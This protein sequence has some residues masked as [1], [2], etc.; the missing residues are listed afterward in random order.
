MDRRYFL[1]QTAFAIMAIGAAAAVGC[2]SKDS[3]SGAN[4]GIS[5]NQPVKAACAVNNP[6]IAI[7]S[8]HGHSL[9]IP[10]ADIMSE[11]AGTYTM[12]AGIDENEVVH[13]HTVDL[14][15]SE[16]QTLKANLVIHIVSS[17]EDEHS[18]TAIITCIG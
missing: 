5:G 6:D 18:H 2:G 11:V 13:T 1:T 9:V 12:T 16:M 8:N 4:A 14:S 7:T 3:N 10:I 15:T 17:Y